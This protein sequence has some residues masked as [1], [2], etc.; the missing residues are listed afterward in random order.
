MKIPDGLKKY[1]KENA[2]Q[3]IICTVCYLAGIVTANAASTIIKLAVLIVILLLILG[4]IFIIKKVK[5][6]GEDTYESKE[7][8][9]KDSEYR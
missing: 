3:V 4:I 9:E 8:P 6:Y 5:S 2:G 7:L 1:L